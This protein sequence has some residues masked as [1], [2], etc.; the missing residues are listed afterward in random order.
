MTLGSIFALPISISP[1]AVFLADHSVTNPTYPKMATTECGDVLRVGSGQQRWRALRTVL[2]DG[3]R[4]ELHHDP[5]R[6]EVPAHVRV[7]PVLAAAALPALPAEVVV[8]QPPGPDL[9]SRRE[10][11]EGIDRELEGPGTI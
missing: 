5:G 1:V 10:S 11:E 2:R 8:Q 9:S 7:A 4:E 6:A 3:H